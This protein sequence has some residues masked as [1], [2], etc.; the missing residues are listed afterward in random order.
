MCFTEIM[1]INHKIIKYIDTC[2]FEKK[3]GFTCTGFSAKIYD[4][5]KIARWYC[6]TM[7]TFIRHN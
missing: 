3:E 6:N 1:K 7:N 5:P 4:W 2:H